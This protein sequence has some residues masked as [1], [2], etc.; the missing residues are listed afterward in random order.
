MKIIKL[1][2]ITFT[3]VAANE[4]EESFTNV[5]INFRSSTIHDF[6]WEN[7]KTYQQKFETH[8]SPLPRNKGNILLWRSKS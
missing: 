5:N 1:L 3:N 8:F 6:L 2:C 7:I 4:I